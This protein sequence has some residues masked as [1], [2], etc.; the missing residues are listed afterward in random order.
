MFS[1]YRRSTILCRTFAESVARVRDGSDLSALGR[2]VS[3]VSLLSSVELCRTGAATGKT[4]G[5]EALS[6]D[7]TTC[8]IDAVDIEL[9]APGQIC[10][11][12]LE[13][14]AI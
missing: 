11:E 14:D 6:L 9:L 5:G 1:L 10:A 4:S 7:F 3:E 12:L 8:G 13:M 2:L